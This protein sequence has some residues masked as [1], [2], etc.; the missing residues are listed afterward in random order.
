MASYRCVSRG[1]KSPAP[2]A[3]KNTFLLGLKKIALLSKK[4]SIDQYNLSD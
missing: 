3:N 1:L 4:A 2:E